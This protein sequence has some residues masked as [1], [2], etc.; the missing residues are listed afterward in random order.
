MP[1]V[2][3]VYEDACGSYGVRPMDVSSALAQHEY[4]VTDAPLPP[5]VNP[6]RIDVFLEAAIDALEAV[7]SFLNELRN[8]HLADLHARWLSRSLADDSDAQ[9]IASQLLNPEYRFHLHQRMAHR[10]A[11][12]YLYVRASEIGA[13][14]LFGTPISS[15]TPASL[16]SLRDRLRAIASK[17]RE[18]VALESQRIAAVKLRAASPEAWNSK[19]TEGLKSPMFAV[20]LT[21]FPANSRIVRVGIQVI[22]RASGLLHRGVGA[23]VHGHKWRIVAQNELSKK[24]EGRSAKYVVA[25]VREHSVESSLWEIALH[26]RGVGDIDSSVISFEGLH[27]W[28]VP[29]I[30]FPSTSGTRGDGEVVWSVDDALVNLSPEASWQVHVRGETLHHLRDLRLFVEYRAP[31]IG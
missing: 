10:L 5:W 16:H 8:S 11:D 18:S 30:S 14:R 13:A 15:E 26:Y 24:M 20:R 17:H 21:G 23:V 12:L 28:S 31:N 27:H 6:L 1:L 22:D 29:P 7:E 2:S 9:Q 3:K 19:R 4:P 25:D